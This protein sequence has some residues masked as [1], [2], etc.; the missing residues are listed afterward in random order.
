MLKNKLI[1]SLVISKLM[2]A[3]SLW[4][5]NLLYSAIILANTSSKKNS[6][7]L[8]GVTISSSLL[9]FGMFACYNINITIFP[10]YIEDMRLWIPEI[11]FTLVFSLNCSSLTY[12]YHLQF[13]LTVSQNYR[14]KAFVN[15]WL[16]PLKHHNVEKQ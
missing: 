7:S 2:P 10:S 11:I 8:T 12:S 3:F 16:S 15:L 9:K 1:F 14:I 6:R 5:Y 13:S 4:P